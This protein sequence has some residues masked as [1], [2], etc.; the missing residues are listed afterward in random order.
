MRSR[1]GWCS[2]TKQKH[3]GGALK[4][5]E[6]LAKLK[7][8]SHPWDGKLYPVVRD[9]YGGVCALECKDCKQPLSANN[10]SKSFK[11][12]TCKPQ[13]LAKAAA[14]RISLPVSPARGAVRRVQEE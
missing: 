8:G 12:H 2:M 4:P 5:H 11:D 13:N 6:L 14:M 3:V 1:N 10:P 7:K 9:E